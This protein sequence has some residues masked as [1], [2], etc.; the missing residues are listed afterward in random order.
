MGYAH[1]CPR[2]A[3][4]AAL[5]IFSRVKVSPMRTPAFSAGS[6][7]AA[8]AFWHAVGDEFSEQGRAVL[9]TAGQ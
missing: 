4:A 2:R 7:D 5:F 8:I 6:Y 9:R 1:T 3:G